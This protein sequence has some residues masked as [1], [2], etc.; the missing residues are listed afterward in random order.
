VS[1]LRLLSSGVKGVLEPVAYWANNPFT[2][3]GAVLTTASAFSMIY[4]WLV[5]EPTGVSPYAG[6]LLWLTLPALFVLGLLLVPAGMLQ[7]RLHA[8]RHGLVPLRFPPLDLNSPLYRRPLAVVL[9]LTAVNIAMLTA[10]T[11]RGLHYMDSVQFCGLTCHKVMQPE[12]SAYRDSPHSRVACVSCH[13]G[14][15]ASWFV[16]SKLSGTE[17]I[18]ATALD[19][20]PK[21]IPAP[22][23]NL[24]PA[25]ETCEQ[26][27]WPAK[28][29]G[30]RMLTRQ[31]Y[32]EDENNTVTWNVLLLHI[33]G[34]HPI[35][36]KA[37]GIHGVHMAAGTTI[38][39]LPADRQRQQIP[40]VVL[41]KNGGEAQAFVDTEAKLAPEQTRAPRRIMDCMDCHNRPTHIFD[42]PEVAV[43]RFMAAGSI[44]PAL[45]FAKKRAVELLRLNYA[46]REEAADKIRTNFREYYRTTYPQV[47]QERTREVQAA[48][49]AVASLYLRN[50]FPQMNVGWGTYPDNIGHMNWTGCFRCHGGTHK[51]AQGNFITTDCNA[52]HNVLAADD[53]SPKLLK[54]LGMT[55]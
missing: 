24:R 25:R 12:F 3:A 10:A 39:Y 6:I 52:C 32:A 54:D 41:R 51:S 36:G 42:L 53:P 14:P 5:W 4:S 27:H 48:A 18:F 37:I 2:I 28:F 26:C 34:E 11:Y 46:S 47:F 7:R 29:T 50:V 21:P 15:G 8:Y 40:L 9:G 19:T 30:T 23:E 44:S 31:H 55:D 45:P 17:Q 49:E 35:T 20:Y 1:P 16:R 43:D 33:G 13:I 22:V 38:E